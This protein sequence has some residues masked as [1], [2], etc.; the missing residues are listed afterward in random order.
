MESHQHQPPSSTHRDAHDGQQL[1]HARDQHL[2][3]PVGR[4]LQPAPMLFTRDG[5][6]VFLGDIYRGWPAFLIGGG[7]SLN[8]HDLAL[9]QHR[10]V[11][12]LAVNNAAA[13]VRPNLW[14]SVDD[15]GNFTDAIWRD[16]G[17]L[18]FVPLCHME[19]PFRVRDSH[20]EL[21]P[22][23]ERVGDM[24]GVFGFRR[25]EAFVAD[26]WLYE[27][28]FNWGNHSELV[29]A[30]GN[31]GGRSVF[32]IALRLLF[33]LGV[34]KVYLIG[35]DFRMELGKPNYAFD[36][37]RTRGAVKNNNNTYRILNVRLSQ[38]KPHFE[39]E[40][41]EVYNCTPNSGLTVFPSMA[42]EEAVSLV[43]SR[44][45]PVAT[46]GMYEYN[47]RQKDAAKEQTLVAATPVVPVADWQAE[48]PKPA[49]PVL[50]LLTF[51][52]AVEATRLKLV[53]PAWLKY[54]PWLADL[55]LLLVHDRRWDPAPILRELPQRDPP[56][57]TVPLT[58]QPD[59]GERESRSLAILHA[60][61]NHVQTPWC[62]YLDPCTVPVGNGSGIS[63]D[64]FGPDASGKAPLLVAHR[65][66]YTKPA[67]ALTRL[68]DW[69]DGVPGL[70]S[71]PRLNIPTQPGEDR[72]HHAALQAWCFFIN[73]A[74]SR[75]VLACAPDRLPCEVLE[76]Y[77]AYC[78][79]RRGDHLVRLNLKEHGWEP[80]S[81]FRHLREQCE[82]LLRS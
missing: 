59:Q 12:T 68:D 8:S 54:R 28:T 32:Y 36:Q 50:S 66:G 25:N 69:A 4:F 72:V 31:R 56:V 48:Q 18:K 76:T 19:K 57:R 7:P 47:Q 41:F 71:F 77:L 33:Y 75:E 80:V 35:C 44:I 16:P 62:L 73:V 40:G 49:L 2:G 13:V 17:I 38:L 78:G 11:L 6:N 51:L 64:W 82:R 5:H 1:R 23:A 27:D 10:G 58:G 20:G 39:R 30:S 52:N 79:A 24:P 55:P 21:V 46:A 37:D 29:D 65:W 81:R 14:T 70:R 43:K 26:Q 3:F 60:I 22:S 9:L 67:D 42:Y 53:W 15:P 61:A 74:W 45:P 34:R 63:P